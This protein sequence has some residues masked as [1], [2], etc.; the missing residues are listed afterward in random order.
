MH[1]HLSFDGRMLHGAPSCLLAPTPA[2]PAA[3]AKPAAKPAAK[4]AAKPAA[5]RADKPAASIASGGAAVSKR[6][7]FLVNVSRT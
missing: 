2:E 7:T 5:K 6:V 4:R 1:R 3:T